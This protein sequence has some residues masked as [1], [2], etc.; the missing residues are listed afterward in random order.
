MKEIGAKRH[1]A[2]DQL[3]LTVP[4]TPNEE[5]TRRQSSEEEGEVAPPPPPT[6]VRKT[7]MFATV[8][9]QTP[10]HLMAFFAFVYVGVEVTIG[11]KRLQTTS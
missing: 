9:K 5:E 6:N 1:E 10:M 3:E 2:S 8:M 4:P 11:G 7:G